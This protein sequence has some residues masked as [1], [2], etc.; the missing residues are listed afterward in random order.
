[1]WLGRHITDT[2]VSSISVCPS[3]TPNS[4]DQPFST[5][6]PQS[7]SAKLVSIPSTSHPAR[8]RHTPTLK[9]LK[10]C[11]CRATTH[12][13]CFIR[14]ST[15]IKRRQRAREIAMRLNK[16]D[17]VK[18]AARAPP[19]SPLRGPCALVRIGPTTRATKDPCGARSDKDC[20][21]IGI[22]RIMSPRRRPCT[23]LKSLNCPCRSLR[24]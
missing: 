11:Y 20:Q 22:K 14:S 8:P 9:T 3:P 1:M 24:L 21:E 15:R 12:D 6:D 4:S 7:V 13:P 17:G 16:E 5:T 10:S 19:S 23:A 18:A 2:S